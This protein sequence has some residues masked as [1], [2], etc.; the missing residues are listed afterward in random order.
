MRIYLLIIITFLSTQAI[1]SVE[2]PGPKSGKASYEI[3]ANSTEYLLSN[4]V[5][6]VSWKMMCPRQLVLI[7]KVSD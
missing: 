4:K 7:N 6:A 2:F 5:V 1:G 3:A